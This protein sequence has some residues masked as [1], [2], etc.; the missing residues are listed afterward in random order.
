MLLQRLIVFHVV[1]LAILPASL[2]ITILTHRALHLES[3]STLSY[4]IGFGAILAT[5]GT[6]AAAI[7]L[8]GFLAKRRIDGGA[9]YQGTPLMDIACE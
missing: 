6:Y 9:A 3:F 5:L 8:T 1:M 4:A 2:G 7:L